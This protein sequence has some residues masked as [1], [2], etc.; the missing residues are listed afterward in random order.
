MVALSYYAP[1][2]QQLEQG[3]RGF[4]SGLEGSGE[5]DGLNNI[6]RLAT[7]P[8]EARIIEREVLNFIGRIYD[9]ARILAIKLKPLGVTPSVPVQPKDAKGEV[10]ESWCVNH[11]KVLHKYEPTRRPGGELCTWCE[12]FKRAHG[13]VLPNRALLDMKD[14]RRINDMDIARAM[15]GLAKKEA[16][17]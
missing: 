10:P 13:D 16:A 7:T 11:Y 4:P 1:A 17:A 14:R 9:D 15:P 6:E 5:S 12:G 3:K 2:M 8:D